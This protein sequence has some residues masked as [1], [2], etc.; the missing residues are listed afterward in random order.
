ME[1]L[2]IARARQDAVSFIYVNAMYSHPFYL[3]SVILYN[4]FDSVLVT[5]YWSYVIIRKYFDKL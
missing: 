2:I 4:Y 1:N 3:V 5:V